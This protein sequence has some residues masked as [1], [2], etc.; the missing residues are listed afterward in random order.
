MAS[1]T[2]FVAENS[3][4]LA[5]LYIRY[6]RLVGV[7]VLLLTADV[8]GNSVAPSSMPDMDQIKALMAAYGPLV[9]LHPDEEYFPSSVEWFFDNGALLYRQGNEGSPVRIDSAGSSLPQG[10]SNDGAFWLDLPAEDNARE[11]VKRGDLGSFKAYLHV[12]PALGGAATDLA[13]WLFYPFNGP[14]KAK[15][16]FLN[17]KL[18]R[19]G[20]HVGDWEHLTLR[21]SNLDGKLQSV[22]FSQ[23]GRGQWIS[24]SQLEY[25]SGTKPVAYASH[26]GHALYPNAGL[27]LQGDKH[28]GI[29]NDMAK[30]DFV[31]DLGARFEIVSADNLGVVEP[32]WLSYFRQWGPKISYNMADE[33]NAVKKLLPFKKLKRAFE[34]FVN[35][36]PSEV[37]GQE[38][39]IG[40]KGKASWNGDE[41]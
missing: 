10:G 28:I 6:C 38:G 19:I 26:N 20:S 41:A 15:I 5:G 9:Y 21:I 22:Y 23:H 32:P 37:L 18:G 27:V 7:L 4:L 1:G 30:S 2:G 39:P 13:I 29:R 40:P 34:K 31:I 14:A 25:A 33:I 24:A 8:M 3:C 11:S 36:L 12:K 35:G 17:V 16:E